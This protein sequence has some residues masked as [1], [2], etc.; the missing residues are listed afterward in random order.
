MKSI[1][2]CLWGPSWGSS[3]GLRLRG[4]QDR[5]EVFLGHLWASQGPKGNLRLAWAYPASVFGL[6]A[7]L[8]ALEAARGPY[9]NKSVAHFHRLP[10][11][12]R[13][14]LRSLPL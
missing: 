12:L 6:Q 9:A 5:F 1:D 13:M 14:A 7:A 2:V 10:Y 4:L 11:R 8:G 3:W